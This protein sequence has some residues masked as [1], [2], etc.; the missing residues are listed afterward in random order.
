VQ[1]YFIRHAQS[2][3][4]ALFASGRGGEVR[5][6]DPA[7][8]DVGRR[9]AVC[10]AEA[11][12]AT[13]PSLVTD[14]ADSQ[15]R[16]GFGLTH[17]YCSLMQRAV[18]TGTAVA[19][20]LGLPLHAWLDW[21]EE[22]GLYLDGSNGE[23][24]PDTG[25]GRAAFAR[26]Y[27]NLVLP[28]DLTD[29]G[30]WVLPDA[31]HAW[32]PFEEQPERPLRARRVL[33]ELIVRHPNPDDRVAVISHGGFYNHIIGALTDQAL[34]YRLSN[35]MN[36]TGITRIALTAESNYLVYQNR[37]AHLPDELVTY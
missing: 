9:Q 16:A 29:A 31:E 28:D 12:A 5:S 4:N 17:I 30:W 13:Q 8:T 23:R 32:R 22:G 34:P 15:N 3:N 24:L 7:L 36:N 20:R 18:A 33:A 11:L 26:D 1:L 21:H 2:E 35:L 6:H 19:D 25:P 37:C 10:L 14:R 27:P